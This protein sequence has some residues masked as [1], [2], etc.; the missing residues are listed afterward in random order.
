MLESVA[1]DDIVDRVRAI[2]L[3]SAASQQPSS[4]IPS[5]L[6]SSSS[7]PSAA[8]SSDVEP[9]DIAP[10]P[11]VNY[12]NAKIH[13]RASAI[14]AS[15]NKALD[16]K[17]AIFTVVGTKEPRVV[18]LFPKTTCSCPAQSS[19]YHITA[20]R[21]AIWIEDHPQRRVINLTKLRKNSRKRRDK[22]SGRNGPRLQDVDVVPA[23]D[24]DDLTSATVSQVIRRTDQNAWGV[25]D[26]DND[27]QDAWGVADDDDDD[28]GEEFVPA[29]GTF[30]SDTTPDDDDVAADAVDTCQCWN[31]ADP[32]PEKIGNVKIV[33]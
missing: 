19:C 23:D 25:A 4:S 14:L 10:P 13:E 5:T 21:K 12:S 7:P 22:T 17:L 30:T 33:R 1:F 32:P 2:P 20:A 28:D 6:S 3:P 27:G 11:S 8:Q 31:S 29:T 24:A 15:V 26:D 18:K 9:N 16:Y